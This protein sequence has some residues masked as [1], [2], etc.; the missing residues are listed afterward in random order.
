[1]YTIP[2]FGEGTGAQ[3]TILTFTLSNLNL[4]GEVTVKIV[5]VGANGNQQATFNN[6][7]WNDNPS[8]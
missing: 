3:D 7:K 8:S 4:S 2:A 5:A 1:T 6:F